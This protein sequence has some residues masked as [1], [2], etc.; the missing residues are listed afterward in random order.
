MVFFQLKHFLFTAGTDLSEFPRA[1]SFKLSQFVFCL[2]SSKGNVNTAC[3]PALFR[4]LS[5]DGSLKSTRT[6]KDVFL[7]NV[8]E[9]FCCAMSAVM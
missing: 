2:D 3:V 6:S 8:D 5:C 9:L 4:E 1:S 7:P